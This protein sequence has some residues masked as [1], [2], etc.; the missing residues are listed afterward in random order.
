MGRKVMADENEPEQSNFKIPSEGEKLLQITDFWED[1]ND[2]DVQVVKMEVIGTEDEGLTL[3]QRININDKL[4]SFFYARL[5]LKAIGVPYK[6]SFEIEPE[7]W[8]GR[9]MYA[10]IKHSQSNG[11]T[12][13]N[14]AEYN[15]KKPVEQY[16]APVGE[17]TETKPITDPKDIVW[18]E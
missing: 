17:A 12:Y 5:F 13:A 18:E 3:L 10:V 4:K 7:N 15:F 14:I 11:K 16:K 2:S 1:K 8:V 6:G 9:Q